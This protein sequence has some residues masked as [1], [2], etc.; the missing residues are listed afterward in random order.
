MIEL[1]DSVGA[2]P[3]A[4]QDVS[5]SFGINKTLTW[6]IARLIQST[7]G[8]GAVPHVPGI[9]SIE[10]ILHATRSR[11]A[12]ANAI[13]KVR[14][15]ARDFEQMI[16]IH[17]GDRATLDL[18]IDGLGANGSDPLELSRKR[19]F[20]GN[21]GIYGVQTR[22]NLVSVVVAP[23]ADDSDQLDI[24]MLRGF[25]GLRR[26]R[27]SARLPI[28]RFRQWSGGGQPIGSWTWQ[29]IEEGADS[30]L[31]RSFSSA[32]LPEISS[33]QT[34]GGMDYI[35]EPGSIGNRGAIDCFFADMLRKAAG[36]YRTPGDST[37]EFGVTITVPTEHLIFDLFVHESLAPLL[38]AEAIVY[39]YQFTQGH[40]EGN[41]DE[42]SRLPLDRA[43]KPIAGHP[44]AIATP[45]VPKYNRIAEYVCDRVGHPW[46][47]FRGVRLDLKYPPLGASAVMR[48]ELPER[49]G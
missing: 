1:Y 43:P 3:A 38:D 42:S 46:S 27:S 19:A 5:R 13:S 17:V 6:K 21:S 20:L 28:L 40:R 33:E 44:P 10:K 34:P 45:L 30:P 16:E 47:A 15:A 26:L 32:E 22:T 11:G 2:D 36:R 7:D 48:F 29:P 39:A 18:V 35:L 31:L 12:S 8:L 24:S 23:N 37:G 25:V 41:W 14:D 4:P 9:A 49:S